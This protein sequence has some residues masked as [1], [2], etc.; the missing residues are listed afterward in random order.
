MCNKFDERRFY[1]GLGMMQVGMF[2]VALHAGD[3]QGIEQEY[4]TLLRWV[5]LLV[6]SFVVLYSAKP[7]F[8]SAWRHLQAGA[9]VMDLPVSLAIG[10]AWVASIWATFTGQGQ[11]YFDSV[12]MFTFFLLLGRFLEK[13]AR[14]R[15]DLAWFDAESVLPTSVK[16]W[17]ENQWQE[18]ARLQVMPEDVILV[19]RG[20]T[21]PADGVVTQGSSAIDES[22]FNGE[23]LPR[24]VKAGDSVFAGT[25]N[26]EGALQISV[27]G[28]YVDTRLAALQRSVEQA[29]LEKPAIAQLADRIASKFIAMVLVVTGI[30]AA[31]WYT[32]D[33]S[34][35]LWISLSVLVISCPCALALA[36]PAAL[37]SAASALRAAVASTDSGNSSARGCPTNFTGT[38]TPWTSSS[39]Q[40][41]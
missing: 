9:L 4:Q 25:L 19:T 5:S 34:Q 12:V 35:A 7:F 27:S 10:L 41:N 16:V 18:T 38:L 21:V 8:T 28:T 20:E 3:I 30:T 15:G 39:S 26:V 36:T 24:S 11:V 29:Q 13:R 23:H 14:Q 32:I 22:T 6:A 33:P 2:A 40:K 37:T 1:S 17:R 31:I